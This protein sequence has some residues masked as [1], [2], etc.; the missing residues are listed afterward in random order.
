[1]ILVLVLVLV[2]VL[3][4]GPV[5]CSSS[6]V[7]TERERSLQRCVRPLLLQTSTLKKN[8]GERAF[9]SLLQI[10]EVAL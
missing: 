1:M 2:I 7:N 6:G 9:S 4:H 8:E 5:T 10:T 3:V